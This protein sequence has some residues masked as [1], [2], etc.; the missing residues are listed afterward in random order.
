MNFLHKRFLAGPEDTV[1]IAI[2]NQANVMMLDDS[3]FDN[4]KKGRGF[5]YIGGRVRVTPFRLSPPHAGQWNLVIDLG[6]QAGSVRAG[7]RI[8]RNSEVN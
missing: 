5:K 8:L 2:D 3:N 1:E 7:F 4:Y 6:G